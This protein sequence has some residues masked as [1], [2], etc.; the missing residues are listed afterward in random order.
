MSRSALSGAT[1]GLCIGGAESLR[2]S[3]T[4]RD[5]LHQG[6]VTGL[7]ASSGALLGAGLGGLVGRVTGPRSQG[8]W[9]PTVT[10]GAAVVGAVL[11][12]RRHLSAQADAHE[13]WG[14]IDGRPAVGAVVGGAVAAGLAAGA[15][16][17]GSELI[18]SSAEVSRRLPGPTPLWSAG[19][20]G[21]AVAGTVMLGRMTLARVL[22]GLAKSGATADAALVDQTT[23]PYVSGNASSAVPYDTLS[24]EGRRFVAWRVT[25]DEMLTDS[26]ERAQQPIRVFVGVQTAP[27]ISERVELAIAELDRLDAWS[28]SYILAVSPA[29][30]G[31]ANSVPVEAL[32]LLTDGDCASVSVQYGL[33]PSMFSLNKVPTAA[34]TFRSLIERIH[35][36]IAQTH[37][38]AQLLLYGESLGADAAQKAL[39]LPPDLVDLDSA[40][41][42]EIDRALFVG[43]PGGKSLRDDLLHHPRTVHVDRWQALPDPLPTD[44]QLWFLEHQADPVTRFDRTLIW[45]RPPWLAGDPRGRNIPDDMAWVPLGTWQQVLLD[46]AYATQSQSG[47]FRSVGHDY[48][49]DLAPLVAAAFV[50]ERMDRVP[51]V[52][53]VLA[54]RE[55]ARDRRLTEAQEA[56]ANSA[57]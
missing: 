8:V 31:Y 11:Q 44:V 43:T 47:V 27:G 39:Q 23:D 56:A 16:L 45:N 1:V 7:M 57:G 6:L 46:V 5:T 50:P 42:A 19:I 15:V 22:N 53:R 4:P 33:L 49:A 17:G 2:P 14:E 34:Q 30:T 9:L 38:N 18:S 40:H 32:E 41:V 54:D 24:R 37:S 35:Q 29:G 48:R 36:R 28:K 13:E 55:I 10:A 25:R 51:E 52:Q 26:G 3:L 12:G 20:A 21:A